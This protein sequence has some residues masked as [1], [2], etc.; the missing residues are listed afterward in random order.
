MPPPPLPPAQTGPLQNL[1]TLIAGIVMLTLG[2]MFSVVAVV[3]IV[4]IGLLVWGYLWWKTREIRRLLRQ[5]QASA[6]TVS[7]TGDIIEG[8]AVVVHE[9]R[10]NIEN[11]SSG[12]SSNPR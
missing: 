6:S 5:A 2:L 3:V 9:P 10:T 7:T 1:L 4:V 8:E 11:H 12:T